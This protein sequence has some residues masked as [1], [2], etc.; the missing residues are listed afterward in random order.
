MVGTARMYGSNKAG[1]NLYGMLDFPKVLQRKLSVVMAR[2][3]ATL[4]IVLSVVPH[5]LH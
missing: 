4:R 1:S 2:R 3:G 5:T